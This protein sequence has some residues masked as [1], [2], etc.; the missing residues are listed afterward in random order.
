MSRLGSSTTTPIRAITSSLSAR[1]SAPVPAASQ[2]YEPLLRAV[3]RHR[4]LYG[5]F[6]SSALFDW[7]QT[8]LWIGWWRG[9][10][11]TQI[12]FLPFLP[13]TLAFTA[14]AWAL[15]VVPVVVLRKAR[16]TGEFKFLSDDWRRHARDCCTSMSLRIGQIYP[17]RLLSDYTHLHARISPSLHESCETS[18]SI[19]TA[20]ALTIEKRA[21]STTAYLSA[22]L[23]NY[24]DRQTLYFTLRVDFS[25]YSIFQY[26]TRL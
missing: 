15:G 1:S 5:I 9:T 16:L 10:G 21:L 11:F 3:L 25:N 17:T 14:F 4:L 8:M 23:S 22:S 20:F 26:T 2:T 6:L 12:P 13:S 18:G 7:A 24:Y 19:L